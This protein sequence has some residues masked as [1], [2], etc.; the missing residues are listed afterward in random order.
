MKYI[1]YLKKFL[2]AVKRFILIPFKQIILDPIARFWDRFHGKARFLLVLNCLFFAVILT[3]GILMGCYVYADGSLYPRGGE[4]LDLRGQEISLDTYLTLTEKKPDCDILWDVP[5]QGTAYSSDIRE[6]AVTSLSDQDLAMLEYFPSLTTL[7]GTGCADQKN[8]AAFRADRKNCT[9]L[10]NVTLGGRV[11]DQDTASL[12]LAGL[13]AEEALSMTYLP[14]LEQVH[15]TGCEDYAFLQQLQQEQP[16]WNLGYTVAVAGQELSHTETAAQLEDV[17]YEELVTALQGLNHLESLSMVNP[18]IQGDQ[19][20]AIQEQYP[21]LAMDWQVELLGST[22][23]M[24]VE[25]IDLS[26]IPVDNLE[27]VEDKLQCLP[28]LNKLIMSDCGIDN[29]TMAQYRERQREHYNVAWTVYLSKKASCRTDAEYFMPIEQ[30]E[31]YFQDAY[32]YNLRYC[33][34]MVALD[35]GHAAAMH[36]VDFLAFMPKLKYLILA[37][38]GIRYIDPIVNCQELVYLEVDWSEIQD[39]TPIAQLKNLKD[40]N[41][42]YTYCDITP[43]LQMT[44]LENLWCPKRSAETKALLREHLT[45]THLELERKSGWRQLPGYYAMRDFFGKPYMTD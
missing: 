26:G 2:D 7:D 15:V 36:N 32:S 34:D 21:E 6:L 39:Y 3:L 11:Y 24:D 30:G 25:K 19:L 40:L 8:L 27:E 22:Y 12:E 18:R 44:W 13:T 41:L 23:A 28:Q 29:E 20:V 10:Y 16:Q 38:S 43:I 14:L 5:F 45:N 42:T 33:E 35:L 37:H 9:V 17:K 31:Y 4:Q 1:E